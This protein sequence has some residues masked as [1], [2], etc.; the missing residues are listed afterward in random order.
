MQ[1]MKRTKVQH[2][3][4]EVVQAAKTIRIT[5]TVISTWLAMPPRLP[6][7]D[8]RNIR[9][10]QVAAIANHQIAVSLKSPRWQTQHFNS[11]CSICRVKVFK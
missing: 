10:S 4:V 6:K 2:P 9:R 5:Y 8:P 3:P 11:G 1:A 7:G